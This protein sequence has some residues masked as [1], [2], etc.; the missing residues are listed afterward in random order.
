M[1]GFMIKI[2][3]EWK[4]LY[5]LQRKNNVYLKKREKPQTLPRNTNRIWPSNLF[6]FF[7][8]PTL[9]QTNHKLFRLGFFFIATIIIYIIYNYYREF[10]FS[11]FYDIEFS[12]FR[13]FLVFLNHK[14]GTPFSRIKLNSFGYNLDFF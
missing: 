13:R 1:I 9:F 8:L 3:F 5:L 2:I 12:E 4:R 11:S 14:I 10:R 7:Q 6:K